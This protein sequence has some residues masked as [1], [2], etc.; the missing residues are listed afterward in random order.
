MN[1]VYE[2][3]KQKDI[4]DYLSQEMWNPVP[5]TW[6][7]AIK[8]GFFATWPGLTDQLVKKHYSRTP[9][10]EKGHMKADRQGVR[11]TKKDIKIIKATEEVQTEARANEFY[12]KTA[13]LT[14]KLCSDQTGRFPVT[15]R[16]GNKHVMI[17]YDHD[18]NAILARPLKTKSA[19]EQLKNIQEVHKFLN[20][21]GI[22]PNIHVM[23]NECPLVVKEYIIIAK[24]M[25]LLLVLP[26]THRVNAAEKAIESYK[27]HFISV[28]ATLHPYFPLHLWCRL[29]PLASTNLNLLRPSRINP[30]LSAEECLNGVFD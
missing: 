30:R 15:S 19:E 26:C 9:E 6:I 1:S 2:L 25:Q 14:S 13:D 11:S 16:K 4:I 27:N 5:D 20:D 28:L 10:T 3:K 8:A 24:N 17:V 18:S 22:H 23:D 29:I 7:K 21:R 12:L